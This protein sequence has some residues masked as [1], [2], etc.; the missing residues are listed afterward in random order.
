MHKNGN[1]QRQSESSASNSLAPPSVENCFPKRTFSLLRLR[2]ISDPALGHR[3]RRYD[4]RNHPPVPGPPSIIETSPALEVRSNTPGRAYPRAKSADTANQTPAPPSTAPTSRSSFSRLRETPL[5]ANSQMRISRVTFDEPERPATITSDVSMNIPPPYEDHGN[6]LS[7]PAPRLSESSRSTI[8]SGEQIAYTTTTT[9]TVS[10]T[11]TFWRIPRRKK[12]PQ[13]LFPLPPKVEKETQVSTDLMPR[14]E[15]GS[16]SSSTLTSP[17]KTSILDRSQNASSTLAASALGLAGPGTPLIRSNSTTSSHSRQSNPTSLRQTTTGLSRGRSMTL[18]T[19]EGSIG[20]NSISGLFGRLR[21]ESEPGAS[22]FSRHPSPQPYN[23]GT[24]PSSV[25]ASKE[26]L[27]IP[28]R[29]NE[30]TPQMYLSRMEKAVSKSVL[31][32]LLARSDDA[33]HVAVLK[34]YMAT[35]EFRDDPMDMA[36]R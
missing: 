1:G 4:S 3:S 25:V 6:T 19:M 14:A 7:I 27:V 31:A 15:F 13:H 24:M 21:R 22:N 28:E 12:T 30:D 36:L 34:A 20:R 35:F 5:S 23:S 18:G 26:K 10:T 32:S 16:G 29:R 33:F 11:T 9:H 8:S 2:N 17:S